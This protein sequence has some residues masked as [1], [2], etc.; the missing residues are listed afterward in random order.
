MPVVGESQFQG[1]LTSVR[2]QS[3]TDSKGRTIVPVRLECKPTNYDA[4]AV[5]VSTL[6]G[7]T[8]GYLS[9]RDAARWCERIRTLGG[10]V[11]CSA[12]LKV[13]GGTSVYPLISRFPIPTPRTKISAAGNAGTVATHRDD[14]EHTHPNAQR[15][16]SASSRRAVR[17]QRR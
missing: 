11:T 15:A 2:R 5:R 7:E 4:I 9:R 12:L 10:S 17:G 8:L 6:R 1:T 13:E 16:T 3:K 14:V